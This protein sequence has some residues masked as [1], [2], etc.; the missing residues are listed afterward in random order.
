[1]SQSRDQKNHALWWNIKG[2]GVRQTYRVVCC[3]TRVTAPFGFAEST[4][5]HYITMYYL[6]IV[7]QQDK[8][9]P[10]QS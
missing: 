1:M 7:F 9:S 6:Y 5:T 2:I 4:I 8:A 3:M 10:R